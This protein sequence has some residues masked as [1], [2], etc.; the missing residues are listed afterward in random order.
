MFVISPFDRIQSYGATPNVGAKDDNKQSNDKWIPTSTERSPEAV[1]LSRMSTLALLSYRSLMR[2]LMENSS[3]KDWTI[4]FQES[5][6]SIKSYSALLRVS[7]EVVID[8]SCCSTG[9]HFSIV[10]KKDGGFESPFSRSLKKKSL[11]PKSLRMKLYKNITNNIKNSMMHGWQPVE[12][13]VANLRSKFG[14][15]AVFFYN[16]LSP[17]VIAMLWRPN[18]FQAQAFSVANTEYKRPAGKQ[19]IH[20]SLMVTNPDDVLREV[21]HIAKDIVVDMKIL[22]ARSFSDA[23][24]KSSKRKRKAYDLNEEENNDDDKAKESD[25]DDHCSNTENDG[26]ESEDSSN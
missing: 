14:T 20:D 19:V 13:L 21:E 22:D 15:M 4:V 18:T 6:S 11:G 9:G 17:N 25:E 7:P 12:E 8:S 3:E 1:F 23:V 5:P 24:G 10:E 2:T 26:E 16:E